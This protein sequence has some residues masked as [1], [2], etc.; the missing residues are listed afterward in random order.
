M[1][2]EIEN[3]E[4]KFEEKKRVSSALCPECFSRA[5]ESILFFGSSSKNT[6]ELQGE[7][8]HRLEMSV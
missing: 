3:F 1:K 4:D 2:Y 6:E 7:K 8:S 5:I